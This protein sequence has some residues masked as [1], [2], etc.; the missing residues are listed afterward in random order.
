MVALRVRPAPPMPRAMSVEPVAPPALVTPPAPALPAAGVLLFDAAAIK[1]D[2]PLVDVLARYGVE[3]RPAGGVL[4]G[5][6]PFHDD[7]EPSLLVDPR[8]DHFHCLSGRCDARG[9]VIEFVMRHDRLT[10]PQACERLGGQRTL[11]LPPRPALA[12]PTGGSTRC[13]GRRR[14]PGACRTGSARR[15]RRDR[16]A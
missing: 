7:H 9:D 8:D 5:L 1:R 4:L 3:L 6:C 16:H 11:P 2:R 14:A 13:A 12:A 15:S 10:F